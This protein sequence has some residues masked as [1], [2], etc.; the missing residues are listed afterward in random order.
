ME[1]SLVCLLPDI[2]L[3]KQ[4]KADEIWMSIGILNAFDKFAADSN[5]YVLLRRGDYLHME[6]ANSS[7]SYWSLA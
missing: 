5:N 1:V 6:V 3:A 2:S 7:L 4:V